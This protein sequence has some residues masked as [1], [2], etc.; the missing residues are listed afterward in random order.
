MKMFSCD[1][2]TN[3]IEDVMLSMVA[4]IEDNTGLP[5]LLNSVAKLISKVCN[6]DVFTLY[7][8]SP[9]GNDLLFCKE[10]KEGKIEQIMIGPITYGQTISSYVAFSKELI[11]ES[12]ILGDERFPMGTGI[13]N[14]QA[15][16]LL[17]LPILLPNGDI[18]GV[19]E[20]SRNEKSKPFNEENKQVACMYLTWVG[21]AIHKIQVCQ[22]LEQ[23]QE[24]NRFLLEVSRVIFDDIVATDNL[25]E[26]IMTF[27]KSLVNADRCALFLLDETNNELYADLFDEGLELDGKPVFT[28][29]N[30]IRFS[31][32]KGIAGHVARTGDVVNIPDAYSDSRFNRE[33]DI[34]TGYTTKSILCMPILS[35][36]SVIGVVQMINKKGS[37][38][39]FSS[40]DESHFRVFAVY[41]A[42]ALH[43]SKIYG[44]ILRSDC[45]LAVATEQVAFHITATPAQHK[46]LMDRPLP[47]TIPPDI[48]EFQFDVRPSTNTFC[49]LFIYMTYELFGEDTFDLSTLA[50]FIL[51]VRNSYRP[52]PYHNFE[53]AFTVTHCMYC[54]LQAT[55]GL[56]SDIEMQSLFFACICHDLDHRGFTNTFNQKFETPLASLY[57]T[58]T[59]EQHHFS[60]T[61]F[62]LQLDGHNIFSHLPNNVYKQMLGHI[63]HNILATDLALHFENQKELAKICLTD[64][65]CITN[66]KHRGHL[67]SLMMTASDLS[68]SAK[69]WPVQR[70]TVDHIYEE[71]YQQVN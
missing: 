21:I 16:S 8:V 61:V 46:R 33:V 23:Q 32:E 67:H 40:T 3:S 28:K 19:I 44:T 1:G 45:M 5:K 57:A 34:K 15:N 66:P 51:T 39:A 4:D 70:E 65:L 38:M 20:L 26:H 29:K 47:K 10:D 12:D 36:G 55:Q 2:S 7:L 30:Q 50:R 13:D 42:L 17:V 14:G 58:S 60:Q 48:N 63:R 27:T 31:V 64:N 35:Q 69:Y 54:L 25:T 41:C 59:M 37:D 24:F 43:Y 52:V 6:A 68:L 62:I 49:E 53:H 56:F 11:M 18:L 71:F 22:S 9:M